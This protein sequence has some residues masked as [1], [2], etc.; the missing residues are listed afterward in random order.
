MCK[1]THNETECIISDTTVIT[2]LPANQKNEL[3]LKDE[4]NEIIGKVTFQVQATT[5]NCVPN[6]IQYTRSYERNV[7]TIKCC[8]R[9][10]S[11]YNNYCE[12]VQPHTKVAE[13][14]IINNYPGNSYCMDSCSFFWCQCGLP[15]P[16]C[17]FYKVY[18]KPFS[19]TLF[20]TFQCPAWEY[21]INM[22]ITIETNSKQV[23]N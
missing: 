23:E 16:A 22:K 14:G 5:I 2:I 1:R 18:A 9:M 7:K 3:I 8:P 4:R 20:E 12:N 10:G 15:T 21:Q 17:L 13:F 19:K 11:C 6:R